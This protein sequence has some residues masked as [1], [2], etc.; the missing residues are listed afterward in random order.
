MIPISGKRSAEIPVAV[1]DPARGFFRGGICRHISFFLE[2]F[3]RFHSGGGASIFGALSSTPEP[4]KRFDLIQQQSP[5]EDAVLVRGG[6]TL[7]CSVGRCN[8]TQ[9]EVLFT[10]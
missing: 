3:E 2:P 4:A 1:T 9:V 10:F 5:G 8:M 7:T 6:L